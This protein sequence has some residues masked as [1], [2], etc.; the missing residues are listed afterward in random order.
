MKTFAYLLSIGLLVAIAGCGKAEPKEKAGA[1][2]DSK[3]TGTQY[4]A[5]SEPGGAVPVG[6]AR[7]ESKDGD[8]VTLVGIIGG[9]AEPF[10]SGLAA[11]T[12][13]DPK[14]KFC[15]PEENCPT[16]WDYCCTQNEVKENIA[17]VKLVDEKGKPVAEDARQLLG[18]KELSSVVVV[19][20]AKRDDQNNLSVLASQV[21][22]R[23]SE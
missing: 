5:D 12:I 3:P 13:V 18:I 6:D 9:S 16:P 8:A 23:P 21:F 4:L 22:I 7:R 2:A 15:P 17:T 1:P 20:K 19:G 14:V 10:V 11:F